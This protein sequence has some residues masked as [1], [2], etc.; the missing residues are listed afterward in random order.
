MAGLT[1]EEIEK[2][3]V[4]LDA[5]KRS[6]KDELMRSSTGRLKGNKL[7][8][9]ALLNKIADSYFSTAGIICLLQDAHFLDDREEASD[10]GGPCHIT[11]ASQAKAACWG[12]GTVL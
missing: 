7:D 1:K 9:D 4:A 6:F 3:D 5:L 12:S 8:D 10:C 11:C 2:I